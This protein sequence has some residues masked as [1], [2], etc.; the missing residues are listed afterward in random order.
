[1][2]KVGFAPSN[3]AVILTMY[4]K[5]A[6]QLRRLEVGLDV[7]F[8][9]SPASFSSCLGYV[10]FCEHVI[11]KLTQHDKRMTFT[12]FIMNAQLARPNSSDNVLGSLPA[13]L[14][15]GMSLLLGR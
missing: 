2:A 15:W 7:G 9:Q 1:M 5:E 8:H 14:S 11:F 10:F 13:S 3:L 4:L 12:M 6:L